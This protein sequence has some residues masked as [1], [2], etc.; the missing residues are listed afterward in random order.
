[1]AN[2]KSLYRKD[3]GIENTPLATTGGHTWEAAGV[4][5]DFVA[6]IDLLKLWSG[7]RNSC[8]NTGGNNDIQIIDGKTPRRILELGSGC[9]WLALNL[10]NSISQVLSDQE[11]PSHPGHG[12]ADDVNDATMPTTEIIASEQGGQALDW[13]QHNIGQHQNERRRNSAS[14]TTEVESP[15]TSHSGENS[16]DE[17]DLTTH[18]SL[19]SKRGKKELPVRVIEL[20]WADIAKCAP[21]L[22]ERSSDLDLLIG[23]DLIYNHIGATFL[24]QVVQ[25]FGRPLLYAHTFH[26]YDHLD[27]LFLETCAKKGLTVREVVWSSDH[28]SSASLRKSTFQYSERSGADLES[29]FQY[30]RGKIAFSEINESFMEEIFPQKRIAVLYITRT[31]AAPTETESPVST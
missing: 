26:R 18:S 20:D 1:M 15:T 30:S 31:G 17:N 10:A 29:T 8:A 27:V 16:L 4:L 25:E 23:S 5:F 9:G 2:V 24:P 3:L 12:L 11:S 7:A 19:S 13:L 14:V 28:L 6:E 22:L 21:K